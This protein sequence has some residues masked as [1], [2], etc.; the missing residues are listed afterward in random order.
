MPVIAKGNSF[1]IETSVDTEEKNYGPIHQEI[2][3]NITWYIFLMT[4]LRAF[5]TREG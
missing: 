4:V 1:G 2:Y 5:D 3:H